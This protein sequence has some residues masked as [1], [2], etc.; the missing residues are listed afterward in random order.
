LVKPSLGEF[1]G[2]A[3]RRQTPWTVRAAVTRRSASA[4]ISLFPANAVVPGHGDERRQR[5]SDWPAT[6]NDNIGFFVHASTTHLGLPAPF[7][8]AEQVI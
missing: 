8:L 5:G 4:G 6:H 1:A 7:V 3:V 2:D